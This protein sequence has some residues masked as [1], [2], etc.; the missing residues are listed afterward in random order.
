[1]TARHEVARTA[2]LLALGA[3]LGAVWAVVLTLSLSLLPQTFDLGSRLGPARI[4]GLCA[5]PVVLSGAARLVGASWRTVGKFGFSA[6]AGAWLFLPA[7]I[8]IIGE[9]AER[10]G[11]RF[12]L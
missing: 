5:G 3:A 7:L 8:S 4:I 1:M 12:E 9:V 2:I 6:L 11:G 10:T